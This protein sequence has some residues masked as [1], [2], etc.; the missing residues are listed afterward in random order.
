MSSQKPMILVGDVGGTNCRLELYAIEQG[1]VQTTGSRA[2]GDLIHAQTYPNEQ[3]GS[4]LD[5]LKM[6]LKDAG[7]PEGDSPSAACFAMAGPVAKNRVRFTNLASWGEICGKRLERQLGIPTVRLVNDFVGAG[8]GLLTLDAN[9]PAQLRTLVGVPPTPGGVMACVGAGTG[10]G[11]VYLTA[12]TDGEYTAFA[13]EGGHADWC[14]KGP[15]QHALNEFLKSKYGQAHRVSVER[16]VSGMGLADAYSFL[17]STYPQKVNPT[18][19][20]E[21]NAAGD[22][23]G[24]VVATNTDKCNLCRQVMAWF[25]QEYGYEAGTAA[26]KWLPTGGLFL[27]GGLTPKNIGL[28]EGEGSPFLVAYRDK[29][30]LAGVLDG[31]PLHAVMCEDLGLRGA[32]FVAFR[33]WQQTQVEGAARLRAKKDEESLAGRTPSTALALAFAV[34]ALAFAGGMAFQ[35]RRR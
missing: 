15:E 33:L 3:H 19:Q 22:Q 5:I 27:A 21:F 31:I 7:V 1:M 25:A 8:Y 24:R 2:P 12:G 10:L 17:A 23:K 16:V 4:F 34:G 11:E 6:F 20:T 18:V 26:L 9:N 13:S 35:A 32:H 30:R 28:I 14:P 29:G